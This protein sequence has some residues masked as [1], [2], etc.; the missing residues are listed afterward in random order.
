L[1]YSVS[2]VNQSGWTPLTPTV[3][4]VNVTPNQCAQVIFMNQP[5]L[6]PSP[7]PT[8]TSVV[9]TPTPTN[10]PQ[11]A[12][13][14]A[15]VWFDQNANAVRDGEPLLTN[16]VITIKDPFNAVVGVRV[17]NGTEPFCVDNLQPGTYTLTENNPAGY[18]STTPDLVTAT[19]VAG[20]VR[21]VEFGDTLPP[22]P[23]PTNTRVNAPT[24]TP[25]PTS[26]PVVYGCINGYKYD[27][28]V[29]G[30]SGWTILL[31][32]TDPLLG[33]Q[34]RVAPTNGSGFFQFSNLVPGLTY[35]ERSESIGLDAADADHV[36]SGGV[37]Q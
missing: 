16:A 34:S 8:N 26:T 31:S 4:T 15:L 33:Q 13:L 3:Y 6:T 20:S 14:C 37:A 10:T 2:E 17:T 22:T 21:T 19:V 7:T 36:P 23:T 12:R 28:Q 1:L 27:P 18:T 30:L 29:R 25:T 32:F 11:I 35:R 9:P 5:P 24:D